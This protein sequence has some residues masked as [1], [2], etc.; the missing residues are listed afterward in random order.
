[1]AEALQESTVSSMTALTFPGIASH[2]PKKK[3]PM[4]Y[5]VPADQR[6]RAG[7]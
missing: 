3:V 7:S 6:K 2:V 5:Y 1:M 4:K